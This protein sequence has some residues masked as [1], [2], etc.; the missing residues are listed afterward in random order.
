MLACSEIPASFVQ[1]DKP[2]TELCRT[3]YQVAYST[4]LK[5]PLWVGEH[6][7]ASEATAKEERVNKF[8]PDPDLKKGQRAE[9]IDYKGSDYDRGHMAP[10]GDM[11]TPAA[12]LES[13]YLSNM[14]PQVKANNR[15]I[16]KAL[17][18][19]TR[20]V[21][22]RKGSV[23]V[24]SGP[25][26]GDNTTLGI[27]KIPVPTELFK[28]IYDEKTGEVITFII[29][30]KDEAVQDLPKFV[31]DLATLKKKAGITLLPG[32]KNKE[33]YTMTDFF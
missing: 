30:N 3:N 29:P 27:D 22:I 16:W 28:V 21:S 1:L 31:S 25:I 33:Y 23:Y 14:V 15:G 5:T 32:L 19:K 6:L 17:E 7:Q 8:K 12:M 20:E 13:F 11:S 26:F 4:Q 2:I 24:F 18:E 10:A 9:L